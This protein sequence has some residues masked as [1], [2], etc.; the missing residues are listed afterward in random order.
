M[1]FDASNDAVL[2]METKI[3][4]SIQTDPE[5]RCW[6]ENGFISS[7]PPQTI[8]GWI[9]EMLSQTGWFGFAV[10]RMQAIRPIGLLQTVGGTLNC[11]S[12]PTNS[13]ITISRPSEK[14]FSRVKTCSSFPLSRRGSQNQVFDVSL[15]DS[16]SMGNFNRLSIDLGTY[17]ADHLD[18][19]CGEWDYMSYLF[20]CE[21]PEVEE[22]P[23]A[24]SP[25]NRPLRRFL[26]PRKFWVR[27]RT[28]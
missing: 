11:L 9:G 3:L 8:P 15:P 19:N 1:S 18:S 20:A 7:T 23:F 14:L 12:W 13:S 10:D 16:L 22:N 17:C 24:E 6:W 28:V 2:A 25:V 27:A 5:E 4:E 26:R 21:I